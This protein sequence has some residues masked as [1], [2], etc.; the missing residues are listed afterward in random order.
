MGKSGLLL[1]DLEEKTFS[2]IDIDIKDKKIINFGG[3]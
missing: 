3:Q 2:P 1:Y